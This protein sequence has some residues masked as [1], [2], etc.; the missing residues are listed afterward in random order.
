MKKTLSTL[1][2]LGLGKVAKLHEC[3]RPIGE[4]QS[5]TSLRK[6][7]G[8]AIILSGP[9]KNLQIILFLLV[10]GDQ[11]EASCLLAGVSQ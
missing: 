4:P 10:N 1:D 11:L 3:A 7:K 6:R 5:A 2:Q 8:R 9:M